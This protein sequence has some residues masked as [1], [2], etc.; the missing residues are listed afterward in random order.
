MENFRRSPAWE[1]MAAELI[2]N[3]ELLVIQNA[4]QV[5]VVCVLSETMKK[6]ARK[7]PI[8]AEAEKIPPK[9]K[10]ATDADAMITI[11]QMNIA[12]FSE[13]QKDIALIRELLKI[14]I[15]ETSGERKVLIG[16]YDL[17]DFRKVVE[18]YGADW[19]KG[20]TLFDELKN[21]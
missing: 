19:D 16:D 5:K 1:K 14:F 7:L 8:Y 10:W 18:V 13:K 17:H 11:Y 2:E 20:P 3:D 21:D 12:N 6:D 4:M 9:Y 15:D